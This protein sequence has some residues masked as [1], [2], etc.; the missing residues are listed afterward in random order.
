MIIFNLAVQVNTKI[1]LGLYSSP[2]AL[3]KFQVEK[4]SG[5]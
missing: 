2:P 3:F 1:E 5:R 4:R